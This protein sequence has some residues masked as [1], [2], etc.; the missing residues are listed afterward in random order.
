MMQLPRLHDVDTASTEERYFADAFHESSVAKL[1][2]AGLDPALVQQVE[3]AWQ[4][5]HAS[6]VLLTRRGITP[7]AGATC[8]D[9]PLKTLLG[10]CVTAPGLRDCAL[11]NC[12]VREAHPS[13]FKSCGA[14]KTVCYCCKEHQVADWPDHKAACKAARK[15]AAAGQA[16]SSGA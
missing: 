12:G 5:L 10:Q 7:H 9:D 13:H 8:S 11:G 14:C 2:A 3:A 1:A 15:D 4:R 16:A 6:G